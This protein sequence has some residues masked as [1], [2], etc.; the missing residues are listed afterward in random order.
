MPLETP[1]IEWARQFQTTTSDAVDVGANVGDWTVDMARFSRSVFA[2]EPSRPTYRLLKRNVRTLQNV[3]AYE[4]GLGDEYAG[5]KLYSHDQDPG[6]SSFMQTPYHDDKHY[7]MCEVHPLDWFHLTN[8]GFLK[9]DVEGHEQEVIRGALGTLQRSNWPKIIL[10]CWSYPWF[11]YRKRALMEYVG[12]LGYSV[13][14]IE[15]PDMFVLER[16]S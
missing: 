1:L 5:M 4:C 12:E 9:I 10:E 16:R 14:P 3:Y 13:V 15:W 7:E 2:F 8:V 11:D 6:K